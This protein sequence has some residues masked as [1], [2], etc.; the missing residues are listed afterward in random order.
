[1]VFF[2]LPLFALF[3]VLSLCI[4]QCTNQSTVANRN[5]PA[6]ERVRSHYIQSLRALDSTIALMDSTLR[7][8]GCTAASLPTLQAQFLQAR[9]HYK[10]AEYLVEY[11]HPH[12]VQF[13]N[14]P[15]LETA[16]ESDASQII[17]PT[18][19][20]VMEEL[21]FSSP[22]EADSLHLHALLRTM[23]ATVQRTT[24]KAQHGT[25][26]DEHV[27]DALRLELARVIAL[28]I[29]GFDSPIAQHS[30]PEAEAVLQSMEEV[31][32]IYLHPA[33]TP[34]R[35]NLFTH[36][37]QGRA[38]LT[39]NND[40]ASFDRLAF[41]TQ[42]ANPLGRALVQTRQALAIATPT[43]RRPFRAA[44]ATLF[45][46]AA[47]AP[48]Y[49]APSYTPTPTPA[50]VELGRTLF[51]DPVLSG[52]HQRAC[53]SC[54]IPEYAFSDKRAKS[55]AFDA[56]GVVNRNAPGL[57]YA[58]L[59]SGLFYDMRTTFLEDQARTVVHNPSEMHGKLQQ[60]VQ[61]LQQSPEYVRAFTAAF[62]PRG[63][64]QLAITEQHIRSALATYIRSLAPFN[65]HFDRY[66]HGDTTAMTRQERHGFNL[67][68]GKAKCGT[69]HFV[70]LFNG[71]A[72]PVF[73]ET[74]ME[75]LG[76]PNTADTLRAR[77]DTDN[78][79]FDVS[80]IE[81]DR[82]AFKTPTLRNVAKTAPYMHNGVYN[83]LEQVLDFYNRGGAAG[84]GIEAPQTLP[85]DKLNLSLQEQSDII[86]FLHTLTD[87]LDTTARPTRLPAIPTLHA[88]HRQIG[89]NY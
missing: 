53:A 3:L 32:T 57:F 56:R 62:P 77:L 82:F 25:I 54:H 76:V 81:L 44:A 89:G 65:S 84:L 42:F 55:I 61:H 22:P 60:A 18:G 5:T 73:A 58:G 27:F 71:T 75:V 87:T 24:N 35:R 63:K 72:P 29:S 19:F 21:L 37:Q 74:D 8:H 67:F 31:L 43:V 51:F 9:L 15:A 49:Y 13:I 48:E 30:L 17:R 80:G 23:D 26:T 2:R 40:F 59:Q 20:Q 33:D 70:P 66:I 69:C 88:A 34:Q 4:I 83:S 1:M 47:F 10:K 78:G 28:G 16:E 85:T 7:Q 6:V 68:M 46:S 50:I 38:F 11:Y 45:D 14:G 39:Y 12:T 86:A 41:I 64:E 52:N 79:R 36:I